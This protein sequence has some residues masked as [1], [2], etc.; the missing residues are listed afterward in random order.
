MTTTSKHTPGP[1]KP[2]RYW[3]DHNVGNF[4]TCD[5]ESL[6]GGVSHICRVQAG[7][8]TNEAYELCRANA[9]L[10]AAAPD[11]LE[12]CKNFLYGRK[13]NRECEAEMRA[14]IAKAEGH[15]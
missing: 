5:I 4:W 6:A 10:I 13:D 2:T 7:H 9:N 12:A 15:A 1:W 8:N 11:L 14:A 3:Q